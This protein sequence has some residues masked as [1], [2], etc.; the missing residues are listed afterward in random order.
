VATALEGHESAGDGRRI[1]RGSPLTNGR[2]QRELEDAVGSWHRLL[3]C[4]AGGG[5][6]GK[7]STPQAAGAHPRQIEMSLGAALHEPR[8]VIARQHVV[9]AVEDRQHIPTVSRNAV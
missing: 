4:P 9:V 6:H 8:V 2:R 7:D 1:S 5:E 3:W